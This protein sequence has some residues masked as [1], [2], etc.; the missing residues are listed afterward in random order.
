MKA[1]V[2][3]DPDDYPNFRQY[4]LRERTVFKGTVRN[5]FIITTGLSKKLYCLDSCEGCVSNLSAHGFSF[6][7]E[8]IEQQQ[9]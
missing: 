5:Q 1:V 3:S 7:A 4:S 9:K 8:C 2:D 6:D